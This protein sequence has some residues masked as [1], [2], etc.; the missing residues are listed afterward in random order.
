LHHQPSKQQEHGEKAT[1]CASILVKEGARG[2][3]ESTRGP[4]NPQGNTESKKARSK[5]LCRKMTKQ[6][7]ET[8]QKN[9]MPPWPYPSG[10]E[11]LRRMGK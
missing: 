1:H 5:C 6:I 2:R 8:G 10:S 11:K 7:E 3:L 4:G 9:S